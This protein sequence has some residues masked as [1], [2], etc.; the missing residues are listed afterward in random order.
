[1]PETLASLPAIAGGAP[2]FRERLPMVSPEGLPGEE[3][4][5]DVRA[6]LATRM[7]TNGA[8]VAEFEQA[9]AAWLGVPHA[10]AVSSCTAGLMLLLRALGLRGEVVLPSFTFHVTAHAVVWNGLAPVFADC[11]PE[12]FCLDPESVRE[13]LSPR[14]AA[15]LA[16]HMYGHPADVEPLEALA[17]G[18][19]LPVVFDAAHAF[20]SEYGGRRVGGFGAA[21]VFSFSPTK[22]LVAGEGG[23][24]TTRDAALARRLR[25]A[26]NYGDPGTYDPELVGVNA[27]MSEFHAALARRGLD[28]LEARIAR[29]NALR[30]RYERRLAGVPG[31]GFQ[32]IRP[33][34]RSTCK[35]VSVLVDEAA[36]GAPRDW[37][38]AALQRE[39]IDV[40]RYFWPPVHR[41]ALY[42]GLWDGRPLPVTDAVS[43]RVVSLPIYSTLRDADAERVAEA[44]ERAAVFARRSPAA[45]GR[46]ALL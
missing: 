26:R 1:M 7:L 5:D 21:E 28:G 41:Q 24:V 36:F 44:I 46:E 29:R 31:L 19:G 30:E 33:G 9:A 18:R 20:G 37:L 16:V 2:L 45:G 39:N 4:L 32:R 35:D 43:N 12:T 8:R 22:L 34:C 17:A 11:D 3:F 15:I 27:R 23:L 40:R 25:A 6:I 42:R 38:F 13:R 14:T 10:V